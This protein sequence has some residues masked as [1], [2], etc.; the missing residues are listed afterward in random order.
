MKILHFSADDIVYG[1]GRAAYRIHEALL[2][3]GMDSLFEV[4]VKGSTD[5]TVRG[6]ATPLK[7]GIGLVRP[8]IDSL[9][10]QMYPGRKRVQWSAS[11]LPYRLGKSIRAV[12]PD[13]VHVH[14]IGNGFIPISGFQKMKTPIVWTL[15]DMWG[16][17]G[18]CH[19][20]GDCVKYKDRCGACPQLS[21]RRE[22]DLSRW[23][24]NRKQKHWYG[25]P[26]HIVAPSRWLYECVR[27]SS[28]MKDKPVE[29]IP[30][31]IDTTLYR[32]IDRSTARDALGIPVDRTLLLFGAINA[33]SDRRKGFHLLQPALR[34]L[35]GS[36]HNGIELVVFGSS[37]PLEP[38]DFGFPVRYMGRLHDDQT[39]ALLYA[40]SDLHLAPSTEDNLP[41]TVIEAM[42]CGTPTVAFRIGGMPDMIDHHQNGYIA[43]PFDID[44]FASGIRWM[45]EDRNRLA[46]L[47]SAARQKTERTYTQTL[48]AG[49]YRSIYTNL[50]RG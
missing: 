34:K 6:P 19:Y 17:T 10:L 41:N 28:L 30:Y 21:S 49:K 45:L 22:H 29:L 7:K 15:H 25:L 20:S 1:A 14:W 16:F 42:A 44:D 12:R 43:E 39:L 8:F 9:P 33:H 5:R 37:E 2:S 38:P 40:A 13:I 31:C 24:W 11:W 3:N 23:V 50:I 35:A 27:E 48:I 26:M 18:G 32:D 4:Q 46:G 47:R 36:G